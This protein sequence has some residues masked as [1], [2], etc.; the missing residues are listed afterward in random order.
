M[1]RGVIILL[2]T[3]ISLHSWAGDFQRF[4]ENGKV[5]LKDGS[6]TIVL[7]AA[8]DALGWSDGNFSVIGQ[9]TGYRQNSK[10]GLL[11]LKKEF[12]TK[13]E[14]SSLTWPGGDRVIVSKAI[15]PYSLKFG[16]LDLEGKLIVPFSYDA[17]DL[18]GLRAIVMVKNGARYEYGLIDLNDRSVLA[19]RYKKITPIGTLRYA[20]QNF[21]DKTALCSEEGK[22]ITDFTIDRIS[23]FHHDLAIIHQDWK[24]GVIDRNGEIKIQPLYRSIHIISPYQLTAR[25]AD[26]WKLLDTSFH[27]LQ[28]AEADE[29]IFN[30]N[31]VFR[32]TLN[33]KSGLLDEKLIPTWPMEYD[34]IELI[35]DRQAIVKKDGKYGL[36]QQDRK[37]ILPI[38]FDSLLAQGIFIRAMTRLSG[39]SMWSVYDTFG[40]K[41]TNAPYELIGQYNG[42]F[43]PVKN[44]GYWGAVDRYGKEKIA[45][46]YDSILGSNDS[47]VSVKFKGQYGIITLEDHW[48]IAP[49]KNPLILL[50]DNHYLEKK[51]TMV[52]LKD[53]GG[54]ILYFTEH[55]IK[56]SENS[57]LETL[58]DGTEKEINLQGQILTR[59]EPVIIR[60]ERTFQPS[61]GFIGIKR[62]GKF[63]FVDTRGRLRI[64]NRYEGIGEFHDGL[65]PIKLLGKWGYV[66]T[67]DEIVI[68]PTF[69]ATENFDQHLA[70]ASRKGKWGMINTEGK[71]ILELRYDSIK[72]LPNQLFL[73]T[74]NSLKGL[75]DAKGRILIEPRFES[76]QV[77]ENNQVIVFHNNRFGVISTDGM[78]LLPFN[79]TSLIY[80]SERKK[81]LVQQKALWETINL[82]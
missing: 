37:V 27:D 32:I 49:Q 36:L 71:E 54:N 33:G 66:N 31:G 8:F 64:A 29:L 30:N 52:F 59:K 2:F 65:A 9:I 25:K 20:V 12:I 56:I 73:L 18:Y 61:E 21:S 57:L 7:P 28:R 55:P 23:E 75:A 6:G 48:R 15:S 41:K 19:V 70:L 16:C 43:F 34:N 3:A 46:V 58:P 10:W 82:K 24:E 50:S 44:R 77:L 60:A 35:P 38:E 39:K 22:W 62:D 40:I 80:L 4:E 51:D 17:I 74:Q 68:Q 69:E 1:C 63:G 72:K 26:E 79:Y 47:L 45:C 81:F 14:Y 13:A 78:S 76:L 67:S 53:N 5:G 11:N 42:K